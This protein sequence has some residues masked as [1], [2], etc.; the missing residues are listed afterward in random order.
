MPASRARLL[1]E[2]VRDTV[3]RWELSRLADP[4]AYPHLREHL[5]DGYNE[6]AHTVLSGSA[7]CPKVTVRRQV[8]A[9]LAAQ[10]GLAPAAARTHAE[11]VLW[12]WDE[13]VG[14][15]VA[16]PATGDVEPRSQVF[17]E[18]GDAMWAAAQDTGTQRGWIT[19]ALADSDRREPVVLAASLSADMANELI[20]AADEAAE[21]AARAHA[22]WWAAD[23]TA[24]RAQPS[25]GALA[26][27]LDG[28]ACTARDAEARTTTSDEPERSRQ[29]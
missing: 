22:L 17:A 10:W 12:F 7:G 1:S 27:L 20:K 16:D 29:P 4:P 6:I 19:H 23:A 24:D 26:T 18:A 21:P 9:M 25:G 11:W 5:L 15:F 8:A 3:N 2:A 28:L 14:V 13:H